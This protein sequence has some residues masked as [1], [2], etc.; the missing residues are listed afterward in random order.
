M[1]YELTAL[2][3]SNRNVILGSCYW[4]VL[5]AAGIKA[6]S[7]SATKEHVLQRTNPESA[8]LRS[9]KVLKPPPQSSSLSLELE[10]LRRYKREAEMRQQSEKEKIQDSAKDIK[11]LR[12]VCLSSM[13][14][15]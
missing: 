10:E 9:S 13:L 12:C 15:R 6:K 1:G 2:S 14:R 7:D 11:L 4:Y 3:I 8:L 5:Y